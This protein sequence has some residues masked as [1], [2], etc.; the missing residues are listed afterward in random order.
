MRTI[1][2]AVAVWAL[3]A[4]CTQV[5]ALQTAPQAADKKI[6]NMAKMDDARFQDWLSRWEKNIEGDA[7]NRYCDKEMG[8]EIGWLMTPFLD[9]FYYGYKATKNAKWID[10]LV[11]WT[12]SWIKRGV[13]EPDGYIGWPKPGAA[14]TK[15]DDLDS[16]NADS[17]LGEAMV[18]RP[19]VLLSREILDTPDLKAKYGAKAESYLALAEKT[20][21]KW[22]KRGGWRETKDG[23]CISLETAYGIDPKSG[24]WT[25]GYEKRNA[26]EIGF[27]HPDNKANATAR[28]LLALFDATQKPAY[29]ERAEK[30]FKLM[31]SRIKSND[32][33]TYQIWN[34]WEP[35]GPWD[36]K[37]DKSPKHWVGVHPNGGYYAVDLEAI[38]DAYEHG[39]VF[40]K[41]DI[42]RFIATALAEKRYWSALAPYNGEIQKKFEDG[43]K[44]DSWGGLPA[45]PWYLSLQAKLRNGTAEGR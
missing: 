39:L 25:E 2:A 34:Y 37:A 16:Y 9:G 17:L 44:P 19:I 36:Y 1:P 27:S 5:Q 38:V 23:G 13:K 45:T 32:T 28:W 18:L 24:Q 15:V 7:R 11:D 21:E 6:S 41:E 8:E 20:Y 29:K 43:H 31:K 14:G 33:G 3:F 4:V 42:D 12:D 30:W 35:A 10:Y 22:D 40:A 26:P